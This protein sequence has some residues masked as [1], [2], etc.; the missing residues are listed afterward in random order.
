MPKWK[1][2]SGDIS[3]ASYGVV[4]A[5]K[6]NR[7]VELVRIEPWLEHDSSAIPSHGLYIVE[8]TTVDFDDMGTNLVEVKVAM[9][10]VGIDEKEYKKLDPVYKADIIANHYGYEDSLSANNLLKALPAKPNEI[11]FL[12]GK[13]TEESVKEANDEMRR[14]ALQKVFETRLTAGVMPDE[15]ALKFA[16]G[17]DEFEAQLK[18][19]DAEAYKYAMEM[20]GLYGGSNLSLTLP[21]F[22]KVINALWNAPLGEELSG[23]KLTKAK[24]I[25]RLAGDD[26]EKEADRLG[27]IAQSLA[28]SMM[29]TLGF[30]W[31]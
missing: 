29:E 7:E 19:E 16:F 6:G 1:Q 14:E 4:L 27:E 20:A 23:K 3:W 18:G 26:V 2:V 5:K 31:V 10:S 8:H 11:E 21:Q 13:E 30:D 22:K 9:S 15:D 12:A 25:L 17:D 28:S 24:Q